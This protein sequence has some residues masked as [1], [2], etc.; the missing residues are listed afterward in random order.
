MKSTTQTTNAIIFHGMPT[1][2]VNTYKKIEEFQNKNLKN[3]KIE[4]NII[5][6]IIMSNQMKSTTTNNKLLCQAIKK[7]GKPCQYKA[8]C[9]SKYCGHHKN[10]IDTSKSLFTEE[11][12]DLL[13]AVPNYPY[14]ED[15]DEPEAEAEAI[16]EEDPQNQADEA[17]EQ[18]TADNTILLK[19]IKKMT[20]QPKTNQVF[21]YKLNSPDGK[22][23][24]LE[25]FAKASLTNK[26]IE[27][28]RKQNDINPTTGITLFIEGQ[29]EPLSKFGYMT[30]TEI[31]YIIVEPNAKLMEILTEIKSKVEG[32]LLEFLYDN[33]K[34]YLRLNKIKNVVDN[35]QQNYIKSY[36]QEFSLDTKT[37][38][39]FANK[40][41]MLLSHCGSF[42]KHQYT[43]AIIVDLFRARDLMETYQEANISYKEMIDEVNRVIIDCIPEYNL[44]QFND[45]HWRN[46]LGEDDDSKWD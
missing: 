44:D 46:Y 39:T 31:Y 15:P 12:E 20:E 43:E 29:E 32:P 26:A 33:Y 23:Y 8:R 5:K 25:N 13:N 24:K 37:A 21:N 17:K 4:K 38:Y 14:F 41:Q 16:P 7:N 11:E 40:L 34:A 19:S 2:E 6:N 1:H 18:L 27:E 35:H 22:T 10:Y 30:H 36:Q 9:S 28:I 45:E 3:K 42:G